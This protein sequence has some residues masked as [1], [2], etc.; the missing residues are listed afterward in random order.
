MTNFGYSYINL[1]MPIPKSYPLPKYLYSPTFT[2]AGGYIPHTATFHSSLNQYS[3]SVLRGHNSVP[4][5]MDDEQAKTRD[6]SP[7]RNLSETKFSRFMIETITVALSFLLHLHFFTFNEQTH[8]AILYTFKPCNIKSLHFGIKI[9][10]S[11][12]LRLLPSCS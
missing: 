1:Q 4:V 7:R 11:G 12:L 8:I 10:K 9:Y 2:S 6:S 3:I 5:N